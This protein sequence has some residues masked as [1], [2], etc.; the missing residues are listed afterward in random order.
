MD[1]YKLFKKETEEELLL[2]A[3]KFSKEIENLFL[4]YKS[5]LIIY[6]KE[7]IYYSKMILSTNDV[8]VVNTAKKKIDSILREDIPKCLLW[9]SDKKINELEN[10]LVKIGLSQIKGEIWIYDKKN[11]VWKS[12]DQILNNLKQLLIYSYGD[13][14]KK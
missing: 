13:V 11:S 6:N 4:E 2:R 9:E 8:E 1:L 5:N 12:K 7:I 10:K 3:K 14:T